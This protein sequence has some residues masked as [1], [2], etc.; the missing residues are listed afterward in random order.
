MSVKCSKVGKPGIPDQKVLDSSSTALSHMANDTACL[1]LFAQ[2]A[3]KEKE[4]KEDQCALRYVT[5]TS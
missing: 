4:G 5:L 3:C 1:A 2:A